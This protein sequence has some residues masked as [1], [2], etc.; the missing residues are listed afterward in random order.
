VDVSWVLELLRSGLSG[1]PLDREETRAFAI[2]VLEDLARSNTRWLMN[3]LVASRYE[4]R[5]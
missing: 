5:R 2:A 4:S 1:P 3:E